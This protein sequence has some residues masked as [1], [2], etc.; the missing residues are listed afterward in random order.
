MVVL[1]MTSRNR[2]YPFWDLNGKPEDLGIYCFEHRE[3]YQW[4]NLF[5]RI[6][7]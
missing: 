2:V 4:R 7:I 6:K 1:G 5:E 3:G